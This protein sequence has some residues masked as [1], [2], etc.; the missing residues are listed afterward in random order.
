MSPLRPKGHMK[1]PLK[2]KFQQ[3]VRKIT[4]INNISK[5]F[6]PSKNVLQI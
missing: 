4:A 3:A 1:S 5:I 2:N 6:S